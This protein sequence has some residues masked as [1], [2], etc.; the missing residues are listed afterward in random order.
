MFERFTKSARGVVEGAV[1]RAERAGDPAVTEEHLLLALLDQEGTR[2]SFAFSSLG[3]A[4]RRASVERGLEQARR[5][6]GMSRADT[7]ALA[8]L[9][10]DVD[11]VVG[12][13][14][15]AHGEGVLAKRKPVR[16]GRRTLT[17]GAKDTLTRTLRVA[18]GHGDRRIGD[19][20]FLLAL[21]GRPGVVADVLSEHGA[22]YGAVERVLYGGSP[23]G[24]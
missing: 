13:L 17:P 14:E 22:S 4:Q 21:A 23:S 18:V 10:I 24:D 16:R 12:R 20:H 6:G 11:A 8:G 9:G 19:E 3:V 15:E 5:R 7:E 2:S 1:V